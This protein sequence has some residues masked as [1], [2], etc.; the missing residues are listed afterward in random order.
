ME[1]QYIL[2][3]HVGAPLVITFAFNYNGDE[4]EPYLLN[5][6]KRL[7]NLTGQ[8]FSK[9]F[10][11]DKLSNWYIQGIDGLGDS[12][13]ASV[14][15]LQRFIDQLQ[16][17]HVTTLGESMGGYGSL[18]YGLNLQA[19]S[20]IAFTATSIHDM[21]L[22]NKYYDHRHLVALENN[23]GKIPKYCTDVALMAKKFDFNGRLSVL[24]G[25]RPPVEHI[26]AT[27][28]DALHAWR[29]K[30]YFP[31][32]E[33]VVYPEADHLVAQHLRDNNLLNDVLIE[34]IAG[35]TPLLP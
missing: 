31:Q 28:I 34:R 20:I 18:L 11:Q 13:A 27:M 21:G 6:C 3:A 4:P 1:N 2:E 35:L 16:P 30:T 17:S 23:A 32:T 25:T 15:N 14:A 8:T 22:A 7:E 5:R 29:I 26:E 24:Y 33:L 9:L 10:V 19:D 12:V